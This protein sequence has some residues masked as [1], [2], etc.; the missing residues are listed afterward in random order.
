MCT[1]CV[2]LGLLFRCEAYMALALLRAV[3]DQMDKLLIPGSTLQ[4][5]PD[6]ILFVN[7]LLHL[8]GG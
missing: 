3:S 7:L 6:G 4:L 5:Q 8:T 1:K 2:G